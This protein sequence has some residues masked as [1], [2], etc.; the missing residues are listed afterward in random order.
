MRETFETV[1]IS[2]HNFP[3]SHVEVIEVRN[4]TCTLAMGLCVLFLMPVESPAQQV[5]SFEQLQLLV[6]SGDQIF[7]TGT[8]GKTSKARISHL[9]NSS[10]SVI[11]NGARRD[12]QQ[13][14]VLEIKQPR[15]DSVWNG[16]AIG[17]VVGVGTGFVHGVLMCRGDCPGAIAGAILGG[18]YGGIGIGVGAGIDALIPSKQIIYRNVNSESGKL[19]FQPILDRSAKGVKVAFSF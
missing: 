11:V 13:S 18:I 1:V 19:R 12:L 17:A 10:L 5:T 3:H 2:L 7:V 4:F 9:S 8:D 6:K 14:D 16:A 15:P